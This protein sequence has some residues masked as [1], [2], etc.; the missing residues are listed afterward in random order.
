[1]NE[2]YEVAYSPQAL[3]DLKGIYSYIALSLC[4]ATTAKKQIDRI[5]AEIR[6]LSTMPERYAA[7][8]L[9]MLHP[10]KLRKVAVNKFVIFYIVEKESRKV[11]IIRI[12]Y[13]G[14]DIA[15]ILREITE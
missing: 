15:A 4:A 14:A 7:V 6:S 1:M 10:V 3:R 11:S 9:E 2:H 5:R 12:L 13:G 8:E